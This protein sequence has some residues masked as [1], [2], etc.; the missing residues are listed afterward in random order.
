MEGSRFC[1]NST[2]TAPVSAASMG[3]LREPIPWAASGFGAGLALHFPPGHPARCPA[4]GAGEP[5]IETRDLTWPR[6]SSMAPW[7]SALE[8]T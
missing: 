1:G 8:H 6:V 2:A 4:A 3:G 7:F 5:T